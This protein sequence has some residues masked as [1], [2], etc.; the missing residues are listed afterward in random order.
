MIWR[1]TQNRIKRNELR[2]DHKKSTKNKREELEYISQN[3]KNY[4]MYQ[5]E[6]K[7]TK[8]LTMSSNGNLWIEFG[9]K[10]ERDSKENQKLFYGVL[11]SLI[12]VKIQYT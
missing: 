5:E 1:S 2:N 11:N 3:N 10:I 7:Q 9:K 12:I 6:S 4:D 8:N